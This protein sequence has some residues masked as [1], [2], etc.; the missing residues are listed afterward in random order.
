MQLAKLH[1]KMSSLSPARQLR[2]REVPVNQFFD[3]ELL[4]PPVRPS[5]LLSPIAGK[6]TPSSFLSLCFPDTL[7][8]EIAKATNQHA[9]QTQLRKRKIDRQWHDT[10][11]QE[12]KAF[13][14]TMIRMSILRNCTSTFCEEIPEIA[15][16]FALAKRNTKYS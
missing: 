6:P 14:G 11:S 12:I 15:P 8:E 16:L 2:P 5:V 4:R 1:R 9:K 13:I 3:D 10:S 7:W